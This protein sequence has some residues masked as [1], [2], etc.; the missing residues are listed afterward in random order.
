MERCRRLAGVREV[1]GSNLGFN[2]NFVWKKLKKKCFV[3]NR[4]RIVWNVKKWKKIFL[5]GVKFWKC[6]TY[7]KKKQYKKINTLVVVVVA[8][9]VG[10]RTRIHKVARSS[11]PMFSMLFSIPL[12]FKS[13]VTVRPFSID[14]HHKTC[15]F[16][17]FGGPKT[18][19]TTK[20]RSWRFF[21]LLVILVVLDPPNGQIC[22]IYDLCW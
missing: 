10:Q 5:R 3:R 16:N 8:R 20:T 2:R 4:L 1:A 9:W 19:K 22:N 17:H 7:K 21:Q 14:I 13:K 6:G 12:I 18:A 11:L 15:I